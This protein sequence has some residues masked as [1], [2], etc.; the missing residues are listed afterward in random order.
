MLWGVTDC[1]DQKDSFHRAR[2]RFRQWLVQVWFCWV[3]LALCS[4]VVRPQMHHDRY[5]PKGQSCALR[6]RQW[7][8][9][10]SFC[11][12]FAPCAVFLFWSLSAG[13]PLGRHHG[14]Y[15]PEG[16]V[17]SWLVS[18]HG[19]VYL[20]V[21]C[22]VL[23]LPEEYSTWFTLGDD[24]WRDSVFSAYW[25][26]SGNMLLRVYGG[27]GS[28]FLYSTWFTRILRS[29]LVLLSTCSVFAAKSTRNWRFQCALVSLA[30]FAGVD[31]LRAMFPSF[32]LR[33]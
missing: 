2:R 28:N 32:F 22:S 4:F 13:P 16:H 26:E 12:Y 14:R 9:Q 31:A 10:G 5:V 7:H 17:R 29:V 3:F 1:M 24:F 25:F 27:F 30:G 11:R 19:P 18:L 6:F 8:V 21:T 23:F 20:A 15:G 33:P